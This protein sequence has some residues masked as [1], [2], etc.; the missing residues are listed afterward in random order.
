MLTRFRLWYPSLL[1]PLLILAGLSHSQSNET[2]PSIVSQ[3]ISAL[4]QNCTGIGRNEAC[5]GYRLVSAEFINAVADDYFSQPSDR[6][7]IESIEKIQT[8]QLNLDNQ[9]WGVGLL[10][11]QANIPNTLPGQSVIFVLIGDVELE[12]AVEPATSFQPAEAVQVQLKVNGNMRSQPS[13]RS[14]VLAVIPEGAGVGVDAQSPDGEWL[15]V[16]YNERIGWLNRVTFASEDRVNDLPVF[17]GTQRM[18][19]QAFYLRTGIGRPECVEATNDVLL[20]QGPKNIKVDLTVNGAVM[21][22]GSTV[23]YRIL[24]N[25]ET[26]EI[27]VLD[28]EVRIPNG[29]RQGEDLLI[30]AG[31]RS[32]VCLSMP[33]NLG[34]DGEANDRLIACPFSLPEQIPLSRIGDEWCLLENISPGVLNYPIDILCDNESETAFV[35]RVMPERLTPETPAQP[36]ASA[37]PITSSQ[38][39]SDNDGDGI[40]NL[41]DAGGAWD[42]GRCDNN[43][44]LK[45]WYYT[46]GWYIAQAD[47][48]NIRYEDIPSQYYTPP[49]ALP[50]ANTN[51]SNFSIDFVCTGVLIYYEWSEL[52]AGATLTV[53]DVFNS[54]LG[55]TYGYSG[56]DPLVTTDAAGQGASMCGLPNSVY[57]TTYTVT[58]TLNQS[59]SL[60]LMCTTSC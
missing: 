30:P 46:A 18:P 35:E 13:L 59:G 39:I 21:Q 40:Q 32:R 6:A 54:E 9:E 44:E 2:C 36:V 60:S 27:L 37:T 58:G 53:Q 25:G 3:A 17:D 57:S 22:V 47:L 51:H 45:E 31:Y 28:G 26:M 43:P 10:N 16:V 49:P 56:Y 50:A 11:L 23:L 7:S 52:P 19:M 29:I 12:N 38:S 5:Y 20:V 1:I 24:D 42:D 8:A 33:D 15:R 41:C 34:V 55:S 4:E 48:G 14:N